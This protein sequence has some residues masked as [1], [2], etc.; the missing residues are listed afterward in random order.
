MRLGKDLLE[1]DLY[2]VLG[3]LPDATAAEL[4]GAYR[5]AVR[6]SHPDLN[7]S[8]PEALARTKQL[9]AAA[10]VLLDPALRHAY[11]RHRAEGQRAGA[12]HGQAGASGP[13]A[14]HHRHWFERAELRADD[15]WV[16][17][18]A[19]PPVGPRPGAFGRQLRGREGLLSLRVRALLDSLS[20]GTQLACAAALCA[21][22]LGFIAM[23]APRSLSGKAP[24]T[25][26]NAW[27]LYP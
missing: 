4:R 7:P 15:E 5:R 12:P 2:R 23:S 20:P 11:D 9:N 6:E 26:V 1:L 25:T 22:A 24:P 27:S 16:A 18:S 3:V 8:H 13:R 21:L 14:G 19:P 17:T 10:R